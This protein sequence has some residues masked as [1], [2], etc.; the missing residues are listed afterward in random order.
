MKRIRIGLRIK[1]VFAVSVLLL[2]SG[3][4]GDRILEQSMRSSY[5]QLEREALRDDVLRLV[6]AIDQQMVKLDEV[7]REWGY[8]SDMAAYTQTRSRT[9]RDEYFAHGS[10]QSSKL[11]GLAVFNTRGQAL[12]VATSDNAHG[13]LFGALMQADSPTLHV[14]LADP[15][16][17][18]SLCGLSQGQGHR[19][20]LCHHPIRDTNGQGPVM[21]TLIIGR[22]FDDAA[23]LQL[24]R[25]TR[26]PLRLSTQVATPPDPAQAAMPLEHLSS[27]AHRAQLVRSTPDW[28]TATLTLRDLHGQEMAEIQLDWPRKITQRGEAFLAEARQRIR[29]ISL[30]GVLLALLL[31]DRLLTAPL[32][33]LRDQITTIA[34]ATTWSERLPAR[35]SDEI[36]DVARSTN[37]MLD[38]IEKQM[39]ELQ[40]L[41]QTNSLTGLPNRRAFDQR[42]LSALGGAKRSGRP[43]ALLMLDLDRFKQYNDLL[44]HLEGDRALQIFADCLRE[45]VHRPTDLP[46][47]YGGEEFVVLLEDTPIE[48]AKLCAETILYNLRQR[49]IHHPGNPPSHIV[50]V[51]AGVCMALP[52]DTPKSLLKRVDEALY[53]AKANGRDQ[54]HVA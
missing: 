12:D 22:A 49:K 31:T 8:W 32:T 42:L 6:D 4:L 29:L 2:L 20:M 34:K 38:V 47:R 30:L 19:I 24:S 41:S 1:S 5:Q 48:G 16:T 23:L 40:A 17:T 54:V 39:D 35:R 33:R 37:V 26:L 25:Q 27:V 50:T 3:M 14:L 28:L 11:E 36:G 51:S 15:L 52:S 9:F 46:A 10:L 45:S 7:A 44:G 13:H 18:N 53:T 21:G 43:L